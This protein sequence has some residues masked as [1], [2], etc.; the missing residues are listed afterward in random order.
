MTLLMT[1][2]VTNWIVGLGVIVIGAG[3]GVAVYLSAGHNNVAP[4]I[5]AGEECNEEPWVAT[6]SPKSVKHYV[7]S[8][9]KSGSRFGRKPAWRVGKRRGAR[10]S[11]SN[12]PTDYQSLLQLAS[13][14]V[15]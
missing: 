13:P 2:C 12:G 9:L 5:F 1:I 6:I 14:P 8:I 4:S 11:Y 3:I 10:G 15:T 7:L